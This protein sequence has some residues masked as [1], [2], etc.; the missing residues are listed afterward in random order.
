[1]RGWLH[2]SLIGGLLVAHRTLLML[3]ESC[4]ILSSYIKC[5]G[6]TGLRLGTISWQSSK[7]LNACLSG[8]MRNECWEWCS[9]TMHFL[10]LSQTCCRTK[11]SMMM[12]SD[13]LVIVQ[14]SGRGLI[15]EF[16]DDGV[17]AGWGG[18]GG[19]GFHPDNNSS[20]CQVSH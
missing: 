9:F 1:M 4:P 12:N 8:A 13:W 14:I 15:D 3:K 16:E 20:M 6:D 17:S 7:C 19:G 11:K 18:G 5:S 2:N 10:S